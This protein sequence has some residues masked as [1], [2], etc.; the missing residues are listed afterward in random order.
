MKKLF[1]CI[2]IFLFTRL[3]TMAQ[4]AMCT[5]TA[6]QLGEKPAEG[7]NSGI[8]YLMLM[9]FVIV[10]IVAYRWWKGRRQD[11]QTTIA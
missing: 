6:Q 8:L 9:P 7:L 1:F 11:N 2:V 4:C 10:G 5:K 3:E